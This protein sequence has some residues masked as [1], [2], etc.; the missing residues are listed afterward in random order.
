MGQLQVVALAALARRLR[1]VPDTGL[2]LGLRLL[3]NAGGKL[4]ATNLTVVTL[5]LSL[6]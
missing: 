1:L 5:F 4:T 2:D 3:K 6:S